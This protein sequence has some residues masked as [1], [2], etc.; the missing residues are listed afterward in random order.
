MSAEIGN[1]SGLVARLR[2]EISGQI[3]DSEMKLSE[4]ST[5]ASNYRV[6]P[7][8]VVTPLNGQELI[9]AVEISHEFKVPVTMRGGGTSI[10]GN[11][12]GTGIIIDT[13]VH[14]NKILEID[15]TSQSARVQPGVILSNLQSAAAPLGLHFGPDPSTQNR[16]TM[17]GLIGNNSCGPHALAY[18]KTAD[19][20][21]SLDSIDGR[22]RR[23][24]AGRGLDAIPGLSNIVNKNLAVLRT[25][26]GQFGRQVSG[27]SFEHLLPE[28]GNN[29]AAALTG[30]EGTLF[31]LLEAEIK[32][33][34]KSPALAL[35]VLGY[36][37]MSS[38]CDD[39]MNLLSF[40]PL[41]MEG[42][43]SR[44]IDVARQH[45][46][47]AGFPVLPNGQGWLMVEVGGTSIDEAL[48][49]ADKIATAAS[50]SST[51]VLPFGTEASTLWR[52]RSDG[53]GYAGRTLRGNQA[54]P[55]WEDSAV[56]PQNLGTYLRELEKIMKIHNLEGVPFGHFGDGC[57]H[58]R[59]D[60]PLEKES[61]T[62]RSFIEEA[63]DLVLS[64]G[65]SPSGE[66]GDGRARSELLSRMYSPQAI[67]LFGAI[68]EIFDPINILNPGVIVNPRKID[69]DLRRPSAISIMNAGGF[70][71][72]DDGGDFT[73]ALHRCVG[74]GKCRA[75][76]TSTGGF[77]CPSYLA[78]KNETDVTRGRARVLQEATQNTGKKT[79]WGSEALHDSLDFCL[80]CKACASDCPAEV[81]MAKYKSEVLYRRYKGKIRPISHYVLGRLPLWANIAQISPKT[82]NLISQSAL[83]SRL[84]L[85]LG[86]MDSRRKL[87]RFATRSFLKSN[88]IAAKATDKP[89]ILLWVDTFTD[90][91]TPSSASSAKE[92]LE[93]IGYEV[94]IPEQSACCGLTWISTGQL[95]GAKKRLQSLLDLFYPF[96]QDG[97]DIVG[98]EPSCIAVIRSDLLDL[99]PKDP[100]TIKV[101]EAT[102]T[103][104][105]VISRVGENQK[106]SWT[107]PDLSDLTLVVQPHCHQHAV[108]GYTDDE[109]ILQ[110][111]GITFTQLSG[112]C[113]LAG[114][115]GMEKGHYE[116]STAVAENAL[117][118]ALRKKNSK[119]IFLADGFSCRTQADQLADVDGITLS[120]LLLQGLKK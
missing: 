96:I 120:E 73:N 95:D 111:T 78:T 38:A 83:G 70:A 27:Y 86:G 43:D 109:Q 39:V 84:I 100:R 87:P 82:V 36:D 26:F 107:P 75:D 53:T 104:A 35:V 11:S 44:L 74:V 32:L 59:I 42:L 113:G 52:L 20:V 19:N 5:D 102:H 68:K 106:L 72:T 47:G 24:K 28:N 37:S 110:S 8:L 56:P 45:W 77:M 22:L 92:L 15:K 112:C 4:Y 76:N 10:A 23:F 116:L 103:I 46:K 13:S 2:K 89:R 49:N 17:G 65:G 58:V 9:T 34:P 21:I 57:I 1:I 6:R 91:F 3:Y 101:A 97:I 25:E 63:T 50:T 30:T 88:K 18:G 31:A 81:D 62:F 48:H 108:M 66:H 94:I 61:T 7:S 105:E 16:A 41:A 60:F 118:P 29:L 114:N 69:Q 80:S 33:V 99:L 115:F 64:L 90:S 119:T 55:G 54:W 51:R 93:I 67:S 40:K 85:K 117:L 79:D 14:M 12:I 98:L 71:F